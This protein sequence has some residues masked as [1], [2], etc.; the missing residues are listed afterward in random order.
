VRW[1]TQEWSRN[2]SVVGDTRT[3]IRL[4]FNALRRRAQKRDRPQD[5]LYKSVH[6]SLPQIAR[7]GLCNRF[8]MIAPHCVRC[9]TESCRRE[10]ENS[11]MT[12]NMTV[13]DNLLGRKTAVQGQMQN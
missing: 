5:L 12:P 8:H 11:Y 2:S 6:A 7:F 4:D 13:N 10:E 3:A 1:R 9:R